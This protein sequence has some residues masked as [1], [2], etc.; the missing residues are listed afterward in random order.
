[1]SVLKA[2]WRPLAGY[3]CT[4]ALIVSLFIASVSAEKMLVIAGVLTGLG[5]LRSVDKKNAV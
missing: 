5:W 1:M 2:A 4:I 3:A